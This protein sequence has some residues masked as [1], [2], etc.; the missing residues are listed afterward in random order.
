MRHVRALKG[1][2]ARSH[3]SKG[4]NRIYMCWAAHLLARYRIHGTITAR[5]LVISLCKVTRLCGAA[6]RSCDLKVRGFSS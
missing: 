6:V 5:V 4:P 1:Y 3:V 2:G